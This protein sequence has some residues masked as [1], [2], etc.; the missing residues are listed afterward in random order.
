VQAGEAARRRVLEGVELFTTFME[1]S[2]ERIVQWDA[3]LPEPLLQDLKMVS[4]AGCLGR[5]YRVL[6]GRLVSHG[7][8]CRGV[9]GSLLY[10][11]TR[12]SRC[13]ASD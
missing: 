2:W 6:C 12:P 1:T 10:R 11:Y 5:L 9:Q 13:A 3:D 7:V 4:G 8:E